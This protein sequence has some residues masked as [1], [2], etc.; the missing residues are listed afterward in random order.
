MI[1]YRIPDVEQVQ[2][3]TLAAV[4]Q[5]AAK[6]TITVKGLDALT[7]Y[8]CVT[9][10]DR[11]GNLLNNFNSNPSYS[12]DV[13]YPGQE[14]DF[15]VQFVKLAPGQIC[16]NLTSVSPVNALPDVINILPNTDGAL[17]QFNLAHSCDAVVSVYN[18]VG[19]KIDEIS[20]NAY[21]N[22][23]QVSLPSGQVYIIRVQT[24]NGLIVKKLYH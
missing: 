4:G 23:L 9:L 11:A 24:P 22:S 20:T 1:T 10:F 6:H 15:I 2:N 17:V 21:D 8:Q 7:S 19:Q 5:V 13:I 16:E 14:K 3:V 12:F 18:V